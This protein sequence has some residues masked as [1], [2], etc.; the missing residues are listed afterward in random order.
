MGILAGK[1][2][3]QTDKENPQRLSPGGGVHV[4]PMDVEKSFSL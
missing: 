4:K 3:S 1:F 2:L